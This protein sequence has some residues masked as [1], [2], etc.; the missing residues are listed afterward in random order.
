MV[1]TPLGI[2]LLASVLTTRAEWKG[3]AGIVGR[4]WHEIPRD[5]L[6]AM[7]NL[8]DGGQTGVVVVAVEQGADQVNSLLS[9]ATTKIVT[10]CVRIDLE[11]DF[12]A[13]IEAAGSESATS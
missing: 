4:F 13:A 9:H 11:A 12:V 3:A 2:T 7:G 6:R 10:D 8:L 5:L 1:A